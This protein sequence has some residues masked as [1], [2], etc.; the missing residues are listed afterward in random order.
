MNAAS[1]ILARTRSPHQAHYRMETQPIRRSEGRSVVAAA[2][3]RA[4]ERGTDRRLGKT[5]DYS[6]K[7]NIAAA[8]IVAPEQAPGWATNRE[9]LWNAVEAHEKRGDAQ[10][11]REVLISLPRELPRD[12]WEPLIR[13]A[14]EPYVL[15]GCVVDCAIHTPTAAD[16]D[17]QPH[18]HILITPRA[19]GP[20]G[21]SR[22]KCAQVEAMFAS[23]GRYGGKRGDALTAERERWA[24]QIND[25]LRQVGSTARADARSRRARGEID[26]DPEPRY[27]EV[28]ASRY[29][30]TKQPS[31]NMQVVG[32]VRI[33]RRAESVATA[34]GVE[35]AQE[36]Q[37]TSKV[38]YKQDKQAV[39]TELLRERVNGSLDVSKL[40]KDDIY[41]VDV[42]SQS[43]TVVQMRDDSIV[44]MRA[45]RLFVYGT[46]GGTAET[47][48]AAI[49]EA[50]GWEADTITRLPPSVRMR[51]PEGSKYLRKPQSDHEI[52]RLVAYWRE[53]GY[54]DVSTCKQGVWVTLGA[55]RLLDSGDRVTLHGPV[56]DDAL[57]AMVAKSKAEWGAKCEVSGSDDFKARLWLEAQRQGVE[58]TNFDPPPH[59]RAMAEAERKQRDKESA[60]VATVADR[61]AEAREVLRFV[62]GEITA[63]NLSPVMEAYLSTLM[64]KKCQFDTR[65]GRALANL[66]TAQL[67]PLLAG[68]EAKGKALL[69]EQTAALKP[70]VPAWVSRKPDPAD[71]LGMEL[72]REALRN[73][74]VRG[75]QPDNDEHVMKF[76]ASQ[77]NKQQAQ[78]QDGQKAAPT[79]NHAQNRA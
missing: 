13:K 17:A 46:Q 66:D 15:A 22:T 31:R 9:A 65:G 18:A 1:P 79:Q 19:I 48:A 59:V 58:V 39:K 3:Y 61:A 10:V 53:A 74:N 43:K 34:I 7:T 72:A 11:G 38:P 49:A 40:G 55:S 60:A 47:L 33:R 68:M 35:M 5:F 71:R 2:F 56:T 28:A 25:A 75:A 12:Q 54:V 50:Q 67:V 6:R 52:E 30:R 41:R 78:Q 27:G 36:L 21:F 29:R 8:F 77:H 26:P 62:R 57:R 14:I 64:D 37:R 69:E 16:G 73:A 23:G 44:E 42:S 63:P 20:D 76:W 24:A 70:A 45:G 51:A 4:G 32:A